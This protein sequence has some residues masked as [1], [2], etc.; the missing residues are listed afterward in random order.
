MRP[1]NDLVT[2]AEARRIIAE[3]ECAT[4]YGHGPDGDKFAEASTGLVVEASCKCGKVT[5]VPRS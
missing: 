5:W 1:E 3:E 2:L 4:D